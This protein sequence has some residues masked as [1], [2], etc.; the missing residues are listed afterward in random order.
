[1]RKRIHQVLGWLA[2]C[3]EEEKPMNITQPVKNLT[4]PVVQLKVELFP[5]VLVEEKQA[6]KTKN[7]E[8]VEKKP[9]NKK[10][11]EIIEFNPRDL[12]EVMGVPFLALS[13]NRTKP[14]I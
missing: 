3:F 14:I 4:S 10:S 11:T 8:V 12:M 13:K 2:K 5:P 6:D 9:R 7:L 1:M